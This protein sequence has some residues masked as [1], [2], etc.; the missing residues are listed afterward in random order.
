MPTAAEAGARVYATGDPARWRDDGRLEF[1]GRADRQIKL[2]GYRIEAG[3]IE[4]VLR[5]Y[6]GG[7]DAIVQARIMADGTKRLIAF[8]LA[9]PGGHAPAAAAL[10]VA[11]AKRL[12]DYMVPAAYV[13]LTEWP[14]TPSG[15][16]DLRAL[17]D[18]DLDRDTAREAYTAP[19]ASEMEVLLA[20]I[21]GGVLGI[22][23]VG[24]EDDFFALGGDSIL[25]PLADRLAR[26]RRRHAH[27]AARPLRAPNGARARVQWSGPA[28]SS[29]PTWRQHPAT[30]P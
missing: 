15:K 18:P 28:A 22:E 8:V 27:L 17:P 21:W 9:D 13:I 20:R 11:C 23:R 10:R 29:T 30:C 1:L 25:S 12:P 14:R 4:H 2:R 6:G 19:P 24:D 16:V 26:A 5:E 7:R 3:E